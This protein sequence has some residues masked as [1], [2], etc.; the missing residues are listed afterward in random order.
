MK[1]VYCR[2]NTEYLSTLDEP[3]CIHCAER[4]GLTLCT[5][6]GKYVADSDFTCDLICNDCIY[7]TQEK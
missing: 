5:E 7:C 3:I 4:K 1:C 2:Q 6:L